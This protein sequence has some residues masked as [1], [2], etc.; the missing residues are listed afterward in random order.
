[1]LEQPLSSETNTNK[2]INLMDLTRQQMREFFAELGEKPFRADQLV[3]WIYHFGEDNFD[4]MT[5]INK[6]LREKLKA[7]AEIK[8]PE[9]AVEQRSADGTIKWAMQVGE[10]QV[11]TVYIPEADRATLCVSSQ[12]G[13]A[14]AC[15]FCSTAQQG[16]N[17]NLTVSE[18][19][20]QVWR[21]SKI[22]GN[23]GV[24][25]VR[26]ITNVVMM[27]MGEPLL[28]VANVVPAMEIMLDD[29]AY[30]LSKRRVTL[31]TSGVVPALDMLRDKIDVALAISLHAPNDELRDEIM[32]INKKYNIK[33]LMDSVH[34]YLE[35]SNAN[36]GKVTIEYV[37]LDHVNDGTEHAHQLAQVLKNTP[38]KINL[39]PWNPFTEAPYG[40][41]SNS[42][43]DRFQKTLMEYGFTVIVRKTR[44][45]DIDA[46]CGQLAADVI[47]R[48]KRTAMKRK[49][50]EGIDVKA[51]N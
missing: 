27:G 48:T 40:K 8:A 6:K 25:G 45:D 29:F 15:T 28:N 13:C 4:N 17:R 14:L 47:D 44:G 9:V 21:A 39:I 3:K 50:G 31:S 32:P 34:R 5:N 7:V 10:Q 12:V 22:I 23:F 19:I 51:V 1:M 36:H 33:M 24:T 38:C 46:A 49:F 35:V 43:V 18:I 16:F 26:P 2:K 20:G 11:E 30:G 41:S 42:R 37:L